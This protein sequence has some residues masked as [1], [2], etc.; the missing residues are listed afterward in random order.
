MKTKGDL[1]RDQ[2]DILWNN[3]GVEA[4]ENFIKK[5]GV[6]TFNELR[7]KN[8][9]RGQNYIEEFIYDPERM[10]GKNVKVHTIHYVS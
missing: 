9:R 4:C 6:Y 5:Y 2:E 10:K 1:T 7:N 3:A 8:M